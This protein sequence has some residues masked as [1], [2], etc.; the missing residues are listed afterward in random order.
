MRLPLSGLFLVGLI[1]LPAYGQGVS[2]SDCTTAAGF[3]S[4]R[5]LPARG[6]T[7]DISWS[8]LALCQSLGETAALQ[9]LQSPVVISETDTARV[10]Q[11]IALFGRRRTIDFFNAWQAV[12]LNPVASDAFKRSALRA[13]GS[14]YSPGVGFTQA[15]MSA[16][17]AA[18]CGFSN[19]DDPPALA[20]LP[21]GSVNQI[22]S[23]MAAV[24]ANTANSSTLRGQANCW[25][26][27]LRV[28]IAPVAAMIHGAYVCG[29]T[30][31]ITNSNPAQVIINADV[32][33]PSALQKI[34]HHS[35]V[36]SGNGSVWNLP[37]LI[38]GNLRLTLNATV[39]QTVI[40]TG[41][42]CH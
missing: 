37:A 10:L 4:G 18:T 24:A 33:P 26:L 7:T 25:M 1:A 20:S 23:T 21:T 3:V 6:D 28:D 14:A 36:I 31:A 41:T 17:S 8:T 40:N 32:I 39:F 22:V 9:A 19:V 13:Y 38:R 30:F 2:N 16:T 5:P 42:V 12:L 15:S 35:S 11:F 29:N 27:T 34:E